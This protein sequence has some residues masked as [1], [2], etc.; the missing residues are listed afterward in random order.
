METTNQEDIA[1]WEVES[2]EEVSVEEVLAEVSEVV[3]VEA[4]E[5]IHMAKIQS[6]IKKTVKELKEV[7]AL[8]DLA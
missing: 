8:L 4:W 3:L 6:I 1:E 2:V 5:A 7:S